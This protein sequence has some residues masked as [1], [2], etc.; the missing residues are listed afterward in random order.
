M[1]NNI[2]QILNNKLNICNEDILNIVTLK[3][4]TNKNFK[5]ET[6]KGIFVVRIPGEGTEHIINRKDEKNNIILAQKLGLESKLL[7][8]NCNNGI[9]ISNFILNSIPLTPELAKETEN[10]KTISKVLYKLHNSNIDMKSSFNVIEKINDY[11]KNCKKLGKIFNEEYFR[12]KNNILNL[13]NKFKPFEKLCPC[14]NDLIAENILKTPKKI[15]I[16]DWE[17]A[18]INDFM[19][20]IAS[21]SLEWKMNYNDEYKFLKNYF[22]RKPNENEIK[23]LILYKVIQDFIWYIWSEIK[24]CIGEDFKEYGNIRLNNLKNNLKLL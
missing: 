23:K 9:K 12:L 8:F 19:W 5:I 14:H 10:L 4:L 6:N 20:D 18:G 15:Y 16:I 3:S 11:E 1:I 13:H 2:L 21:C 22:N 24:I 17:Y 7:Y